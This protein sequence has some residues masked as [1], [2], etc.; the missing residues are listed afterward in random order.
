MEAHARYRR[1]P[2]RSKT[3]AANMIRRFESSPEMLAAFCVQDPLAISGIKDPGFKEHG[4]S[5]M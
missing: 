2:F 3:N 1:M 4:N 5:E